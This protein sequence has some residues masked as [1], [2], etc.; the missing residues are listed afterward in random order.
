MLYRLHAGFEVIADV[1]QSKFDCLNDG[2][3][4]QLRAVHEPVILD[5]AENELSH[6][7]VLRFPD[8]FFHLFIHI[9]DSRVCFSVS[10]D[11]QTD[12]K[13]SSAIHVGQY[14]DFKRHSIFQVVSSVDFQVVQLA[15]NFKKSL[16]RVERLDLVALN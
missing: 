10:V 12:V 9:E 1:S 4:D 6:C 8:L 11:T 7:R 14:G 16:R 3:I 2:F 5:I 15:G 13:W